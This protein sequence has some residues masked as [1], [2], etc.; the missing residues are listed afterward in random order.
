MCD[1][2]S[3]QLDSLDFSRCSFCDTPTPIWELDD[4]GECETCRS[5]NYV[6]RQALIADENVV[7]NDYTTANFQ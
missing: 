4:N 6:E 3:E 2:G 1:L 7:R 5:M